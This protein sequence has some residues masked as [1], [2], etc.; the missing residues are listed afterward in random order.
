M[1]SVGQVII[2]LVLGWKYSVSTDEYQAVVVHIGW[3]VVFI[4][5]ITSAS[6]WDV[7]N[8]GL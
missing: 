4:I 8:I 1:P 6:V 7:W 3:W 2:T 5:G